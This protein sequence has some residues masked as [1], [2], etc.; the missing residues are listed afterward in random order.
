MERQQRRGWAWRGSRGGDGHEEAAEEGMG[1]E[2]QQ[3]RGWA[4]RGS[5]GGCRTAPFFKS[6]VALLPRAGH[7]NSPL[8]SRYEGVGDKGQGARGKERGQDCAGT[9]NVV[10][11]FSAMLTSWMRVMGK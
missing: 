11:E 10:E 1:M 3:V 5:P 7:Q 2:R 9:E 8:L 4:W 6:A